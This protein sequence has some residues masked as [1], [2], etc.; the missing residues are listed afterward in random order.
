MLGGLD[1]ASQASLTFPANIILIGEVTQAPAGGPWEIIANQYKPGA[2][3]AD[4]NFWDDNGFNLN[5]SFIPDTQSPANC[6]SAGAKP[7]ADGYAYVNWDAPCGPQNIAL[8]HQDG[9]NIAFGDGHSKYLRRGQFRLQMF[10]PGNTR[11]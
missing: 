7:F 11:G 1:Q 5:N 9:A 8:R 10:R 6:V 3:G 2:W 4:P